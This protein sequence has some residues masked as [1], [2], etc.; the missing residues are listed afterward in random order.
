MSCIGRQFKRL[1]GWLNRGRIVAAGLAV[2]RRRRQ[3]RQ[4]Q[5]RCV[6]C[7]SP[8]RVH[9]SSVVQTSHDTMRQPW[10]TAIRTLI[11]LGSFLWLPLLRWPASAQAGA[12]DSSAYRQTVLGIQN[13]IETGNLDEARAL[14]A[15]ASRH[16]PHNGGLENLLG[17]VEIQQGHKEAARKAFAAAITDDPRLTGAYLNLS[18]MEMD[19]AATEGATRAEA[20]RLCLKVLQLDPSNEEAHYDAAT[21]LFW[22]HEYRLSFEHLEKLS[23]PSRARIGAVALL[24]ADAAA[25]GPP[26]RS[27][28]AARA[29]AANPELSEQDADT[30]LPTL[31]AAKRAD[32]IEE[33]F[34]A[35][36][37]HQPLSPDGVRILGLAQ[38]G[39]GKFQLAR[40]TLEK[41][42]AVNDQ[43]VDIL[44]DLARVAESAN[45]NQGALGYLAHARDLEPGN[46]ALAYEFGATCLR[47]GLFAEARKA[48]GEALRLNPD[49]P[50]YNLGMGTVVSFSSD[51]SQSLPYLT[52]YHT[53]RPKDPQGLLA[54]GS[55]SYRAKDYD[56]A[57]Q[58]LRRAVASDRTAAEAHFFLGRIARQE[59]RIDEAISELKKSLALQPDQADALA[60][61][62]S[63][64]VQRRDFTQAATYLEQALHK[65]PDNYAANFAL[66]QLYAQTGDSRREQQSR[67]F[68][69]IKSMRDERERQMMRAIEIRPNQP[70]EH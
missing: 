62:G 6:G 43:S 2:R 44:E 60:E 4:R 17:V 41:A 33:I 10:V 29:L 14:I 51:P 16:F 68:D 23:A 37:D 5:A 50:D 25:L 69:E 35:A 47:I 28:E 49:N 59:G 30:C 11:L 36:A 53:L 22:K 58:W 70:I 54:L 34:V 45:D 55:A 18:R 19:A 9:E 57:S 21:I 63:I 12:G 64:S 24:C 7:F 31:R 66:L 1:D 38:E 65:D 26:A 40:A 3:E 39:E 48:M 61:L 67:R 20:L 15:E 27:E 56:T 52:R 32:L 46:A 8:L 13:K 42:F